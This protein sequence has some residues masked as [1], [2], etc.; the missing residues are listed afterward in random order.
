MTEPSPAP[1]SRRLWPALAAGAATAA[2]VLAPVVALDPYRRAPLHESRDGPLVR[3]TCQETLRVAR[4]LSRGESVT[5][6]PAVQHFAWGVDDAGE[7]NRMRWF[8]R[9]GWGAMAHYGTGDIVMHEAQ[10]GLL[11]PVLTPRDV[12]VR[13]TLESPQER[14][15]Q[16]FV[17][18]VP[19]GSVAAGPHAAESALR[20]PAGRLFRGDNLLLLAAGVERGGV[21]LRRLTLAP[22]D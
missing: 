10:A 5:F 19:A 9:K 20:I 14:R 21:R 6:D 11:V 2:L 13:L 4:R 17:N 8:L 18:G 1:P 7:Q 12:E 16:A 15:L 3:V 22:A